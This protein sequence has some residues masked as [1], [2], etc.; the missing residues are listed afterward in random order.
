M[1]TPLVVGKRL[2]TIRTE[3]QL[4]LDE[5]SKLTDVSKPMLGQILT[6]NYNFMENCCRLKN[7]IIFFVGGRRKRMY[8]GRYSV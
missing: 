1:E 3:K 8:G 6:Y 5:V 2:K 7:T 4:S